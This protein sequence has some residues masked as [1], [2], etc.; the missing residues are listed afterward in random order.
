MVLE[1]TLKIKISGCCGS[2]WAGQ[3][4]AHQNVECLDKKAVE[5]LSVNSW[6]PGNKTLYHWNIECPEMVYASVLFGLDLHW[7]NIW[8]LFA[9]Y[10]IQVPAKEDGVEPESKDS[11]EVIIGFGGA[12]GGTSGVDLQQWFG[13]KQVRV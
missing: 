9:H 2:W 3:E 13:K 6:K 7:D 12:N 10:S 1:S 5:V 11:Q 8:F 4:G